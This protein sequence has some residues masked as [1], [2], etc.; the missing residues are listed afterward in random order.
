MPQLI[1]VHPDPPPADNVAAN[2]PQAA[3]PAPAP[4]AH[5][6]AAPS[7]AA[8]SDSPVVIDMAAMARQIAQDVDNGIYDDRVPGDDSITSSIIAD[9][10]E[11]VSSNESDESDSDSEEVPST[12]NFPITL[13]RTQRCKKSSRKYTKEQIKNAIKQRFI[14]MSSGYC[15]SV[16]YGRL[17]KCRCCT[18]SFKNPQSSL[19]RL[20]HI[21]CNGAG[22]PNNNRT[23]PF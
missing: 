10:L 14:D 21:C 4:V 18:T 23:N 1:Q 15:K 16:S 17:T 8:F 12:L 13:L 7:H 3:V 22:G 11:S 2:A 20:C 19:I 5:A 6:A 9:D